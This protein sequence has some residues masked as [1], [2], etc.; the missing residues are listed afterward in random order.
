MAEDQEKKDEEKL[1][2]TAE[3]EAIAYISLDQARVL[4]LRHARDNRDF[5]GRYANQELVWQELSAEESED[6][7]RVMLSYRPTRLF[8]GRSGVELFTIDKAGPIEFRQILKEPR[9]AWK[10]PI[11]LSVIAMVGVA[12][13]ALSTWFA[14]GVPTLTP[15]AQIAQYVVTVLPG[16][17]AQLK[18]ANGV[19]VVD[20]A[21]GTVSAPS[22]LEIRSLSPPEIPVLPPLFRATGKAFDLTTDAALLKPIT[23]MVQVSEAEVTLARGDGANIVIQHYRVGAWMPLSTTMDFEMSMAKAHVDRLSIFALTIKQERSTPSA[24][25]VPANTSTPEPTATPIVFPTPLPTATPFALPTAMPTPTPF[26]LPTPTLTPT[27]TPTPTPTLVPTPTPIPTMVPTSTPIPT[28]VPTSTPTPTLVPTPTTPIVIAGR[29][30][31]VRKPFQQGAVSTIYVMNP[32]GSNQIQVS[33]GR[34]PSWIPYNNQIVFVAGG[35]V[36][37]IFFSYPSARIHTMNA[38]GSGKTML[39]KNP[40]EDR[41]PAWSPDQN[42]IAVRYYGVASSQDI[43]AVNPDGSNR[44]NLTENPAYDH[45]PSWSPDGAKIAFV[46]D[47]DSNSEIYVMNADGSNPVN[48]TVNPASD[49]DPSWSRDGTR[50]AFT[51]NRGG[52]QDLYIMSSDGSGATRLTT[53]RGPDVHPTWS[54]DGNQIAFASQRDGNSQIYVIHVDGSNETR[55]TTNSLSDSAPSWSPR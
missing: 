51:S 27:N 8:R 3:G 45:K 46:S 42:R 19:V 35:P 7:Y 1:E 11:L 22:R 55:L 32:D 44:I 50:I 15:G 4:A 29:I 14:S 43:Y 9:P 38:N 47:R 5:Y 49:S 16:S 10:S 40:Y 36:G 34:D 37:R 33:E 30:A 20:V 13:A 23:I 17:P 54:P 48:L 24:S 52:D 21:P 2:F 26:V 18:S 6:F 25:P 53:A 39:A 12:G 41:E 31:F 28:M